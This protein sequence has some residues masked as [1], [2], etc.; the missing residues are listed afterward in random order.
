MET[1]KEKKDEE[2]E[3]ILYSDIEGKFMHIKVGNKES[4]TIGPD[5]KEIEDKLVKLFTIND[6]NC[7]AFVTSYNVE[8]K[9]IERSN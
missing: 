1:K 3:K 8:I 6:I 7:V 4:N 5:I 9:L 2:I